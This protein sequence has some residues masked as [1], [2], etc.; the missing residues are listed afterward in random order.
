MGIDQDAFDKAMEKIQQTKSPPPQNKPFKLN[1][2][3]PSKNTWEKQDDSTN[4]NRPKISFEKKPNF[5]KKSSQD[6][7]SNMPQNKSTSPSI[8]PIEPPSNMPPAPNQQFSPTPVNSVNLYRDTNNAWLAGVCAGIADKHQAD[9]ALVRL[10]FFIANIFAG[11]LVL[12]AY[13][14]MAI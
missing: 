3:S 4:T 10:G 13:I 8:P 11:G 14:V 5:E 12:A 2:V 9:P 1:L 6:I 7:D